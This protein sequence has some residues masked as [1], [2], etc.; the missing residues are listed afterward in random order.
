MIVL[1]DVSRE[2]LFAFVCYVVLWRSYLTVIS[3][4]RPGYYF[5]HEKRIKK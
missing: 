1:R 5:F 4:S 2:G 3:T